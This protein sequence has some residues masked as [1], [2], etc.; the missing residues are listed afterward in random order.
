MTQDMI[1]LG[2]DRVVEMLQ[3]HA[4]S[5]TT[6]R[7]LAD[8]APILNESLC[9]ARMDET[10]AARCVMDNAG[11]PPLAV[12]DG[13]EETLREAVQGGMLLPP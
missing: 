11:S 7:R 13:P 3:A 10:T 9:R 8:T 2:F 6:R 1:T 12:T 5:E 4:V